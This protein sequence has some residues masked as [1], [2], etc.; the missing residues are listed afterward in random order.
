MELNIT[1]ENGDELLDA[2]L[3]FMSQEGV[4]SF[5]EYVTILKGCN[6]DEI[7]TGD[8]WRSIAI[9]S[10]IDEFNKYSFDCNGHQVENDDGTIT[11]I[12]DEHIHEYDKTLHEM[13]EFFGGEGQGD[14]AEIIM[15]HKP[16]GRYVS[17][18]GSYQSYDG[19]YWDYSSW[20]E[21]FPVEVVKVEYHTKKPDKLVVPIMPLV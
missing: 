5:D 8:L 9:S 4:L 17:L 19:F 6:L 11:T 13:I 15:K 14:C 18:S 12:T 21:V 3:K 10:D 1:D 7:S 16:S 2:V 20:L